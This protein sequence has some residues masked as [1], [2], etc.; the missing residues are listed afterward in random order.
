MIPGAVAR[1]AARLEQAAL[2]DDGHVG[3]ATQH[4]LI[5]ERTADDAGSDDHD[6][7]LYG[8]GRVRIRVARTVRRQ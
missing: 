2:F 7:R 4:E 1:G 8:H 3:P 6:A 5:G